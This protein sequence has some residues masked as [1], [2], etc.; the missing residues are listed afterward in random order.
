MS[1]TLQCAASS[2]DNIQS[3]RLRG[4]CLI[5]PTR[6]EGL[7]PGTDK[8]VRGGWVG[9]R[10]KQHMRDT[11]CRR[12]VL[13]ASVGITIATT[14]PFLFILCFPFF[15]PFLIIHNSVLSFHFSTW[16]PNYIGDNIPRICC[17][18]KKVD[19]LIMGEPFPGISGSTSLDPPTAPLS[20]FSLAVVGKTS[21]VLYYQPRTKTL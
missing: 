19:Y 12:I 8:R 6:A 7:R 13:T 14:G 1:I 11:V 20:A 10:D 5:P 9:W 21:V 3:V 15:L 4:G 18:I 2:R 16:T 17:S